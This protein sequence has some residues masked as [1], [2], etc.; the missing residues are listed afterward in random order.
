MQVMRASRI[1]KLN[2][3]KVTFQ[4]KIKFHLYFYINLSNSRDTISLVLLSNTFHILNSFRPMIELLNLSCNIMS[5]HYY[6][7]IILQLVYN[8]NLKNAIISHSFNLTELF[9]RSYI[10]RSLLLF[11]T[12]VK[13]LLLCSPIWQQLSHTSR[14]LTVKLMNNYRRL[15]TNLSLESNI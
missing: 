10:H 15:L 1:F 6:I 5:F 7:S 14:F 8:Q 11:G 3:I 13:G 12:F 9:W 4:Q 2:V